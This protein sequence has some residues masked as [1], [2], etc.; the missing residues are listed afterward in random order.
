MTAMDDIPKLYLLLLQLLP[1]ELQPCSAFLKLQFNVPLLGYVLNDSEQAYV[2]PLESTIRLDVQSTPTSIPSG[3]TRLKYRHNL[4]AA[5]KR[6]QAETAEGTF[7][8]FEQA[9][10]IREPGWAL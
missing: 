1:T 5:F 8:L 10:Q 7:R 4:I 3:K 2:F 6:L 9:C